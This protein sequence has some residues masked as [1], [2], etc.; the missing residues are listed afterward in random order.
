MTARERS[1]AASASSASTT[2]ASPRAT[3]TTSAMLGAPTPRVIGS[4]GR[5][6]GGEALERPGAA[7]GAPVAQAVVE[8]A[9]AALP[10]LDRGR[11][12]EVA[13]P[14]LGSRDLP[15]GEAGSDVGDAPLELGP[16]GDRLA[17]RRGPRGD[18]APARAGGEVGVA[19]LGRQAA[20]RAG[21]AHRAVLLEPAPRERRPAAAVEVARLRADVAREEA[22]AALVDPAQQHEAAARPAVLVHRRQRDRVRLVDALGGGV[23]EP[24]AELDERVGVEAR[25]VEAAR[26]VLVA[27]RREVAGARRRLRHARS[28]TTVV[29]LITAVALSPGFNPSWSA[30]SRDITETTR[31]GPHAMSTWALTPARRTA[32]TIPVSRLRGL[33]TDAAERSR[34]RRASSSWE[35]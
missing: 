20:D 7:L 30:A 15:A 32:R 19:L 3:A 35:R 11:L 31:L 1:I 4:M 14:V 9:L 24:V 12:E 26:V 25:D 28:T 18:L 8:A 17:L 13:A 21:R 33:P 16:R 10:E 23:L 29:A 5:I 2:P 6:S 27:E 22:E 34:R